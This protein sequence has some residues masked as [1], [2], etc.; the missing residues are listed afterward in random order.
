M[1]ILQKPLYLNILGGRF[2]WK[3]YPLAHL[4]AVTMSCLCAELQAL[5]LHCCV[6]TP[7]V[8]LLGL[9]LHSCNTCTYLNFQTRDVG[10]RCWF[11]TT[12]NFFKDFEGGSISCVCTGWEWPNLGALAARHTQR[13]LTYRDPFFS[14]PVPEGHLKTTQHSLLQQLPR[15]IFDTR[16]YCHGH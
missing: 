12:W 3:W 7:L 13:P 10:L 16:W 2:A 11:Q 6:W 9:C 8:G 4:A 1:Y 5:Q 14:L 15:K